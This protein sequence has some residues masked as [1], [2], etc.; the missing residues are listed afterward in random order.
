M[1]DELY[2]I[3]ANLKELDIPF[4][5]SANR[6][7]HNLIFSRSICHPGLDPGYSSPLHTTPPLWIPAFAGMASDQGF[8]CYTYTYDGISF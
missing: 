4:V 2:P 6:P 1:Y 8:F 3:S 5:I 7:C